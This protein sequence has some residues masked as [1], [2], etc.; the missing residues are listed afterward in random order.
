MCLNPSSVNWVGLALNYNVMGAGGIQGYAL[1]GEN[2]RNNNDVSTSDSR[3]GTMPPA[4]LPASSEARLSH[5]TVLIKEAQAREGRPFF[6]KGH[7]INRMPLAQPS[8]GM[9]T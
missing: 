6:N 1:P 7:S 4:W 2:F 9:W 5:M 3:M 8:S